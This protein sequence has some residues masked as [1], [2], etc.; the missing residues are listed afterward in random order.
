MESNNFQF[1]D[2]YFDFIQVVQNSIAQQK[3][4][5]DKKGIK[6]NFSLKSKIPEIQAAV[7]RNESYF[8]L[9]NSLDF[10]DDRLEILSSLLGDKSRYI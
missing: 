4:L 6:I 5:S 7:V 3:F 8:S 10:D 9:S 2:D 1:N